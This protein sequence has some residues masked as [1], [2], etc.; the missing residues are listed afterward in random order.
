[1]IVLT[2]SPEAAMRAQNP[3]PAANSDPAYQALRNLTLSGEAV[4]VSNIE[5]KRDAGTF[6]LRSGAV[7]FVTAV[8]GRVTGAVFVGEGNFVLDAPPS[9]RSMLKLLS[10]E[11]EFSERFSQMVLRFTDYSY[12]DLKKL[13]TR[14]AHPGGC[15]ESESGRT[16]RRIHPRQALQRA[17]ALRD[18]PS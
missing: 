7:C 1:L 6:H 5:L 15:A 2:L 18:R 16:F 13:G 11:D 14:G 4:G 8:N 3:A 10:K 12:E 9:E 17:G